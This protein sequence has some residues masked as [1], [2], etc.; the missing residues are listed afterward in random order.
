MSK[1]YTFVDMVGSRVFHRFWDGK[2][3]KMEVTDS[4]P[5]EL[6][7]KGKTADSTSI[8]GEQLSKIE[9]SEVGDAREFMSEHEGLIEIYGQTS[10]VHQFISNRY[11]SDI[12]FD[13]N[14]FKIVNLDI[15]TAFG[16]EMF[17]SPN[18]VVKTRDGLNE[19]KSIRLSP[20]DYE[21]WDEEKNAWLPYDKSCY[22]AVKIQASGFP[23]PAAARHTILAITCKIHGVDGF[24]TWGLNSYKPK[25]AAD[26]YY[27]FGT[28]E[29]MLA[30]FVG[31]WNRERPD[32]LTG[33][34][35]VGFDV[36]YLV[37]R[38]TKVLG[39]SVAAKL[40]PFHQST[41]KVFKDVHIQGDASTYRILG[42]TV[43]D[44]QELYKK[45]SIGSRENYKLDTIAQL[46]LGE[47]KLDYSE[48]TNLMDLYHGDHQ[49]YMEYNVHDV[50]LVENMDK[51]LNYIFLAIT[52]GFLG[53]VRMYEIFGQVKF[54]DN[55]V[56]VKL[57]E[58]GMQIPP[59]KDKE[60]KGGIEGA[61]VKDP[62]PGL[63]KWVTAFDLTSLYPSI[64]MALGMSPETI[65]EGSTEMRILEDLVSMQMDLAFLKERNLSMAA[66]GSKYDRSKLG[67]MP[68][69]TAGMFAGRKKYKNMMLDKKREAEM[70][71]AILAKKEG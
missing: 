64:I 12:T 2:E 11:P 4:F 42:I 65:V 20:S 51:Q 69:I 55:L 60:D 17:Y 37:N 5:I 27:Q 13:I 36:P 7:I 50:R 21:V 18:Y 47:E 57:L 62:I 39:E 40:S 67:I 29:E 9:F 46:E 61:Y 34:N 43:F 19:L 33:W 22:S 58:K 53:K 52:L 38:I 10:L 23:T 41:S 59:M 8:Y 70:I 45:F 1:H 14:N 6:F 16:D 32:I 54:W 3:S 15:E 63:Y 71:K 56:Y 26:K 49:K 35:V 66:N 31:W 68:E 48:Y 30:S 25:D 24:H 28:E 44:F